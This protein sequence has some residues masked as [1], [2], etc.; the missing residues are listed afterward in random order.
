MKQLY[1]YLAIIFVARNILLR[2]IHRQHDV[3]EKNA[4]IRSMIKNYEFWF[5]VCEYHCLRFMIYF[6]AYYDESL[7]KL[8]VAGHLFFSTFYTEPLFFCHLIYDMNL[9]L[10]WCTQKIYQLIILLYH[11]FHLNISYCFGNVSYCS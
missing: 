7:P 4:E 10:L 3:Y 9:E 6:C 2:E 8:S 1:N 5:W 11:F